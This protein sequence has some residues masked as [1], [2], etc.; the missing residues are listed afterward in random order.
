MK[1]LNEIIR[2]AEL[3]PYRHAKLAEL[4]GGFQSRVAFSTAMHSDQS[5]TILL[6]ETLEV[7]RR[8]ARFYLCELITR[9]GGLKDNSGD[10]RRA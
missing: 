9:A 8:G 10:R 7:G 4:S 6:D 5:D 1:R 2:F 3:E